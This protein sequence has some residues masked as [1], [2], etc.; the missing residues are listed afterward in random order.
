M[1]VPPPRAAITIN[2]RTTMTP[3]TPIAIHTG[4]R[5]QRPPPRS[6]TVI[7]IVLS[8][9]CSASIGAVAA[10]IADA[11][12]A[13]AIDFAGAIIVIIDANAT[14]SRTPRMS[15]PPKVSRCKTKDLI[16]HAGRQLAGVRVLPAGVIAA[17]EQRPVGERMGL[18]MAEDRPR[19]YHEV[20]ALEQLQVR[21]EGDLA[22]RD[23]DADARQCGNL[24]VEMRQ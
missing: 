5:Y 9:T 18:R 20:V 19:T 13:D 17:D 24:R 10:E 21:V 3:S 23:D 6:P 15:S 2:S 11:A 12:G 1:V 22:E 7:S 4:L 8:G 16:H 14:E